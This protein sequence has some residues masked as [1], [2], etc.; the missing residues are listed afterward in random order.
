MRPS[1]FRKGLV[2][3]VLLFMLKSRNLE[4]QDWSVVKRVVRV[5]LVLI[6]R[7]LCVA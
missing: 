3:R 2:A 1:I 6:M 7:L 5:L 4:Y